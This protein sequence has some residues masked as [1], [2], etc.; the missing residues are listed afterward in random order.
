VLL[1][2]DLGRGTAEAPPASPL[3]AVRGLHTPMLRTLVEHLRR[4]E[5]D[6]EV[7]GLIASVGP[8]RLTLAQS[9]ELRA[10]VTS[11]RASGRPTLAWSPSFGELTPGTVGYHLATAF[12][13]IWLQPTGMVTL[14]G[15]AAEAVF[16]RGALDKLG[17]QPQLR[18]RHE[19]KT[20]ADTFMRA[21]ISAPH[22]EMLTRFLGS[23]TETV[24]AAVAVA[25]RLEPDA[26]RAVL[27]AGPL[28]GEEA[29]ER[30]LV[31]HLGY[32]DEAYAAM[33][34]RL[35]A[36]E[37]RL[38]Y[39]ERHGQ[40]AL[41]AALGPMVRL[42]G[43]RPVVG[44]VQASGPIHL[45]RPD[46]RSPWGGHSVG[47]DPLTA[48]L[49]AAG[50]DE[51]VVAVVLRVDS[52]GG[53]YVASD[54]IRRE[55]LVLRAAGTPVV[56]SMASVAAS[57]G[58]YIAM[59]CDAVYAGAGTV[60]GSIGVLAGKSVVRDGLSRLGV[61]RET[62]AG[63]R[64]AA[65][66]SSNR[67]FDDAEL[68]L[69]DRWL[70]DV[71]DDFTAKAAADRGLA[72]EDLRTVARGRVWTGA[73]AVRHGLVDEVGGLEQAVRDA[74][75]RAGVARDE[76][77]VRTIPAAN[78]LQALLPRESSDALDARL[79]VGEGPG[80][81]Q[82]LLP[83]LHAALGVPTPYAGVLSLPPLA[84]PGLLPG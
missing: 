60:T 31:D 76:V 59:P 7:A 2:L 47:S 32:R 27:D 83:G 3:E 8:N 58:Y 17:V 68:A 26:V 38:R 16:L 79:P 29:R 10:A 57:G 36:D 13:E 37:P 41:R 25:R 54:A 51:K 55:I 69:L 5:R 62:V 64:H 71:Y 6:P 11:F 44:V 50:R 49:R 75:R 72:V 21:S 12:D 28:T 48:A 63:S 66:L 67:P 18:Q 82:R 43:H 77:E 65:M 23:A 81:W 84:L 9:E 61:D 1:E 24:V 42:P 80:L 14:L 33:G 22:R 4:A 30:G 78:P 53:S 15:F 73:D 35:G 34:E 45:G 19:Y 70:D 56:A 46:P 20:A 40:S 39:V 74:C 52:P